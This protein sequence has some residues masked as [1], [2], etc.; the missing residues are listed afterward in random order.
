MISPIRIEFVQGRWLVTGEVLFQH[1]L[2][3]CFS[4]YDLGEDSVKLFC[5]MIKPKQ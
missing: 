2:W 5:L 3:H 4:G 1:R